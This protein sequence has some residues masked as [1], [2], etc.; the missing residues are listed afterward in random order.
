MAEDTHS[1]LPKTPA[2]KKEVE[3]QIQPVDGMPMNY[4]IAIGIDKYVNDAYTDFDYCCQ[5]DGE[6]FINAI[7]NYESVHIVSKLFNQDATKGAI[8]NTLKTFI[9]NGNLNNPNNNLILFFSGHGGETETPQRVKT[10]F[11]IPHDTEDIMEALGYGELIAILG[12]LNTKS[13]L[14]IADSCNSGS[15]FRENVLPVNIDEVAEADQRFCWG[16]V[17]SYS[18]Q[19]SKVLGAKKNSVFTDALIRLINDDQSELLDIERLAGLLRDVSSNQVDQR[20]FSDRINFGQHNNSGK[21]RLKCLSEVHKRRMIKQMLGNK[22]HKLDY[23]EQR[24]SFAEF[25]KGDKKQIFIFRG[26]PQ[27]GLDLLIKYA[28]SSTSFPKNCKFKSKVTLSSLIGAGDEMMVWLFSLALGQGFSS[29]DALADYL[30]K[31]LRVEPM[32]FDFRFPPPGNE[33]LDDEITKKQKNEFLYQLSLFMAKVSSD[34]SLNKLMI[35]LCDFQN[36]EYENADYISTTAK[37]L[38]S[39]LSITH[40]KAVNSIEELDVINWYDSLVDPPFEFDEEKDR[41]SALFEAGIRDELIK[42][43]TNGGVHFPPAL[44]RELCKVNNCPEV[45][46]K[47]L[48]IQ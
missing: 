37:M 17:S 14:F 43:V 40:A 6:D 12:W 42:I 34:D 11:L 20:F 15:L 1:M 44:I 16:M 36:H 22:L 46:D 23:S 39:G 7:S 5:K 27:S 33:D 32:L 26:A 4:V 10:G 45:A 9:N 48:D 8:V 29:I 24:S 35:F 28:T 41:F 25:T 13:F 3:T 19:T 30:N 18:N 31:R 47:I 38:G 2:S 21:F